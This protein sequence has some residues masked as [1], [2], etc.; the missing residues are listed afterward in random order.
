MAAT[1]PAAAPIVKLQR[2]RATGWVRNATFPGTTRTSGNPAVSTRARPHR[3]EH[4]LRA[5]ALP[6]DRERPDRRGSRRHPGSRLRVGASTAETETPGARS[7]MAVSSALVTPM[8]STAG[9]RQDRASERGGCDR[10]DVVPS[11]R[12]RARVPRRSPRRPCTPLRTEMGSRRRRPGRASL[13]PRCPATARR[14]A[15]QQQAHRPPPAPRGGDVDHR[16]RRHGR[17]RGPATPPMARRA[18]KTP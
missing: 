10:G 5:T 13:R 4:C 2:P 12:S 18:R 3:S 7:E 17:E 14:L 9:M 11:A 15:H 16:R 6:V 1:K 8:R